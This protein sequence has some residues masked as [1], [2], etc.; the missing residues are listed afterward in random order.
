[1]L[2]GENM[3]LRFLLVGAFLLSFCI[4][5]VSFAQDTPQKRALEDARGNS[6][7]NELDPKDYKRWKKEFVP[8]DIETLAFSND[9]SGCSTKMAFKNML[10]AKYKEGVQPD[11]LALSKVVEPYIKKQF[12]QIREKGANQATYDTMLE[13][14]DCMR[15]VEP[16]EDPSRAY[17]MEQRFG[18]CGEVNGLVLDTLSAIKKRK[19]MDSVLKKY[20]GK[21]APDFSGT[22]YG[23]TKDTVE[24]L[25]GRL[26][27]EAQSNNFESAVDLGS[28]L[29]YACYF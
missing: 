18:A 12:D 11:E 26:Y 28:K 9:Q 17:D 13:Y 21:K 24:F 2:I 8:H 6:G 5:S 10:I 27:K 20:K 19:S 22:A 16:V 15:N 29:T 3:F 4:V 25:V 23:S 1:M 7:A 14:Q